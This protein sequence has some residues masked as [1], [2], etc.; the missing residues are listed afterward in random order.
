MVSICISVMISSVEHL[1]RCLL[2]ICISSLEKCLFSSSAH[3]YIFFMMMLSCMGCLYMFYINHLQL[4]NLQIFSSHLVGLI[5]IFVSGLL[6]CTKL[7]SLI[8]SHMLLLFYFL[9]F[10]RAIQKET[11]P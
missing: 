1:S 5:F 2:A 7:L 8:R 9:C 11:L 4:Y 3:F 10:S 6:C